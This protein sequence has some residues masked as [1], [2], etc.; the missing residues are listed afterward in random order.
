MMKKRII[1]SNKGERADYKAQLRQIK[2]KETFQYWNHECRGDW[3]VCAEGEG[4]WIKCKKN[5]NNEIEKEDR[6]LRNY[7]EEDEEDIICYRDK[8]DKDNSLRLTYNKII[9]SAM[10][11][12]ENRQGMIML[13]RGE[14]EEDGNSSRCLELDENIVDADELCKDINLIQ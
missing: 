10:E 8:M 1:Q 12:A 4:S 13:N 14:W 3:G 6:V 11:K 5:V 2:E 7:R 9:L